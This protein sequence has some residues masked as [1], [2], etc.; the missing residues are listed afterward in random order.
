MADKYFN[1]FFFIFSPNRRN[2][3]TFKKSFLTKLY[4][5]IDTLL[6]LG[7]KRK[8]KDTMDP[9]LIQNSLTKRS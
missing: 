6:I 4:D 1:F 8:E 3:I 7:E 5:P 2:K 9:K